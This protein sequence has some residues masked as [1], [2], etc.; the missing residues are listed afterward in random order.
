[1]KT[2]FRCSSFIKSNVTREVSISNQFEYNSFQINNFDN[3]ILDVWV[4]N[5]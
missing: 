3:A 4:T 5:L 1:M 2:S